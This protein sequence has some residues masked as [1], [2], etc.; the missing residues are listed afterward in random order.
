M[1]VCKFTADFTVRGNTKEEVENAVKEQLG[2]DVY[3]RMIF[4]EELRDDGQEVDMDLR[5]E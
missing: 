5:K 1:A 2:A 4:C 3:D